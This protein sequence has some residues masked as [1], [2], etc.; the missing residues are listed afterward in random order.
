MYTTASEPISTAYLINSSHQSVC[1][2]VYIHFV[3]T[4]RQRFSGNEYVQQRKIVGHVVFYAVHV[5]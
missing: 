5:V 1:L 2:Y 3:A 4:Q